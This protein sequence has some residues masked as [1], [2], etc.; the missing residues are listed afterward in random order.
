MKMI[1]TENGWV[2]KRERNIIEEMRHTFPLSTAYIVD[3]PSI[4]ESIKNMDFLKGGKGRKAYSIAM[5]TLV[6]GV[7]TVTS[8]SGVFWSA[9]MQYIFPWLLD[10]AKV[11]CAIKIA[12]SFYQERR[13]G[14]DEGTGFGALIS[15]GKWYLVFWL[16]PWFV[17]LIDQVGGKMLLELRNGGGIG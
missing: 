4:K 8:G 7:A 2:Q 15:Y 17:E 6:L 11:F 5:P 13:G 14:R 3:T 9:F 16:V 10:V 1:L 12:Q